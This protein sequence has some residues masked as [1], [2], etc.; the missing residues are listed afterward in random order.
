M[1]KW[2]DIDF[3]RFALQ[4][5][6]PVLRG[7]VLQ[8][9]LRTMVV[10]LRHTYGRFD[11]YRRAVSGQ[12]DVTAQTISIEKVLN[13]TFFLTDGQIYLVA[14]QKE[15]KVVCF[16]KSENRE[17]LTMYMEGDGDST[18]FQYNRETI[19]YPVFM[20]Y[21][22]TFLCTSLVPEEDKYRGEHLQTIKNLLDYYKPAGRTYRIIL[23]DYE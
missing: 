12:L 5:L 19:G 22:P 21:V 9:L 2:Y 23:Y 18:G 13:D 14:P 8:A 4:L 11:A 17:T 3:T 6:P 16:F 20:V 7:E 1:Y 10:P 15:N